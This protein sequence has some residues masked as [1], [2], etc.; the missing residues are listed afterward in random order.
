[1]KIDSLYEDISPNLLPKGLKHFH[2]HL[3]EEARARFRQTYIA[4]LK[5]GAPHE[6]MFWIVPDKADQWALLFFAESHFHFLDHPT[7]WKEVAAD[8]VLD[9]FGA[10]HHPDAGYFRRLSAAYPRGRLETDNQPLKWRI[11]FGGDYPPGWNEE[12]LMRRLGVGPVNAVMEY[13]EHWKAIPDSRRLADQIL[14]RA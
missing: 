8:I 7:L 6:G 10:Q 12:R 11:G 9:R 4:L 3:K 14:R 13:D 1:M 5:E 2:N